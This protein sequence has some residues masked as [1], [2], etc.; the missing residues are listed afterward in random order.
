VQVPFSRDPGLHL[1]TN[2]CVSVY[3]AGPERLFEPLGDVEPF[4]LPGQK[5][6]FLTLEMSAATGPGQ[7]PEIHTCWPR[8]GGDGP[9]V[10]ATQAVWER[11]EGLRPQ[12]KQPGVSHLLTRSREYSICSI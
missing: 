4:T 3:T 5:S 12:M 6:L 2:S 11:L 8:A 7:R 1:V 10:Q 9:T